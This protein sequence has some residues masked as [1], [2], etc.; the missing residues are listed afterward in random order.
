MK[1]HEYQAKRLF[2]AYEIPVP[3]G[4]IAQTPQEA[5]NVARE[6]GHR[7]VV[8]AQVHAGGRGRAGGVHRASS[9]E[10]AERIAANLLGSRLVTPQTGPEGAPINAVLVEEALEPRHQL[11]LGLV[12]DSAQAT[13]ALMASEAG[14]T[15]IEE[16]AAQTPE[17]IIRSFV[18]PNL[19]GFRPF[20][21]RRVAF[22]LNLPLGQ[23]KPATDIILALYR[24]FQEKDC[25][26]AEINPLILTQDERLVALD[27][28]LDFDD[29]A[30]Y[31]HPDIAAL[32]DPGQEN[33][34]EVEAKSQ[35]IQNYIKM[36]GDI[37]IV[38]NGAGLAM[39][40]MDTLKAAGGSP[41][42]FLDIGTVN[43]YE[44][45]VHA[46]HILSADPQVKA[47]LVN[48][49]GGMARADVIARGIVEAFK[50]R[51]SKFP[52]VVRLA[53]TNVAEGERILAESGLNLIRAASL[54]EAAEKAIAAAAGKF[55]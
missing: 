27:A 9:P 49:F 37:G 44:R 31:R 5:K 2:A 54:Y 7:V 39:A 55:F 53:G 21:A 33:P 32:R 17:K 25:S 46:F 12:I 40:V 24:L 51:E 13:P 48:I 14:G 30:L 10:E 43:R 8:K 52:V 6:I 38:V 16:I 26:L 29:N 19:G 15:E 50:Q 4:G 35:G 47:V 42:N 20:Q 41:A 36:E 11:Y 3:Q 45:V 23:I 1:I 18:D 34:L 28:K 22:G